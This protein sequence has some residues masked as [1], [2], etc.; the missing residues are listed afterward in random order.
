MQM[1]FEMWSVIYIC[2]D[3]G[4]ST[5]EPEMIDKDYI[6]FMDIKEKMKK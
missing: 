2:H 6:S 5:P 1:S 4:R 3:R